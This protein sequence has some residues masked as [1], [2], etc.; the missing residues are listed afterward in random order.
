MITPSHEKRHRNFD[1][2]LDDIKRFSNTRINTVMKDTIDST[3]SLDFDKDTQTLPA[4]NAKPKKRKQILTLFL[5]ILLFLSVV[6]YLV[7]TN[8]INV[9][10]NFI[11][12]LTKTVSSYI[13]ILQQK[14]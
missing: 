14:Y 1:E 2:V 13:R 5:L 10:V 9:Y 4:E 3:I 12:D 8:E 6:A 11:E 7:S